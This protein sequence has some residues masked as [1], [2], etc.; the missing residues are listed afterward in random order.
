MFSRV[1]LFLLLSNLFAFLNCFESNNQ[2]SL[3][4]S[5]IFPSILNVTKKG[6]LECFDE[7]INKVKI[8]LFDQNSTGID[9]VGKYYVSFANY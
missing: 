1:Y 7:T 3:P 8:P 5:K 4:I 2:I 6:I 9:I